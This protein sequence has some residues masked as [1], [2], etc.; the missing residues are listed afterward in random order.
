MRKRR[1]FVKTAPKSLEKRILDNA[2]RIKEDFTIIL[3]KPLDGRSQKIINKLKSRLEKVW[4]FRDDIKKLEKFSKGKGLES[5]LAG[6]LLLANNPKAPYLARVKVGDR[7][8]AYAIRGKAEKEKL[9]SLQHFDDPVLRILGFVDL[10]RKK[11]LS[12]FSW[13]DNFLCSCSDEF[14]EDFLDFLSTHINLKREDHALKCPHVEA[15]GERESL[16]IKLKSLSIEICR[17]CLGDK[18]TVFEITKYICIPDLQ[19]YTDVTIRSSLLKYN[20]EV[21]YKEDY[22][23]GKMS[24]REFFER[25]FVE[26]KDKLK[27]EGKRIVYVEGKVYEDPASFLKDLDLK[28]EE[29]KALE[30]L[31]SNVAEPIFLD[32]KRKVNL[33]LKDYWRDYGEAILTKLSGDSKLARNVFDPSGSPVAQIRDVMEVR[34]RIKMIS[35]YPSYKELPP[36]ARFIDEIAKEYITRGKEKVL[37]ILSRPPEETRKRSI[38][39]AFLLAL[40][41]A[42]ERK[43]QYRREEIEF[44]EFLSGYAMKLLN[45]KPEEYHENLKLF[46]SMS[47]VDEDLE[48]EQ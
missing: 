39:Y 11:K 2:F 35:E 29:K 33:I 30:I 9:I 20:L 31:L 15:N 1:S 34:E 48:N 46:L 17:K 22:L 42:E 21:G 13:K 36:I 16:L 23:M 47:G 14:P 37:S 25:N 45:S 8:V 41:K 6:V 19:K 7:D 27:S 3:P 4:E 12:L 26:W 43:W 40:G 38:A 28:G 10:S 44:G 32:D 24:D 5:A 18:N